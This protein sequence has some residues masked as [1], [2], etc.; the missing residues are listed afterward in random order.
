[1]PKIDIDAAT[2]RDRLVYPEPHRSV[3]K[4]YEQRR[5]GDAAG[6]T[7]FGVNRVVLAPDAHTALRHWHEVQDEFVIVMAGEVVLIEE[8]A[9]T[10]LRAG[11]CAGFKAGVANGHCFQNRSAEPVVLFEIGTHSED[12]TAHYPDVDLRAEKRTGKYRF[13]HRDGTP[14]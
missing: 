4:G 11:D 10:I 12:E 8:D 5:V 9:E 7:Q 1:M 13:V 2:V 14:Y 3:T 6:L